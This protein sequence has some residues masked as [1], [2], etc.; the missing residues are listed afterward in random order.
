MS[1]ATSS[2]ADVSSSFTTAGTA[3]SSST[4]NSNDDPFLN[5]GKPIQ[6]LNDDQ[7]NDDYS[8][9]LSTANEIQIN[10]VTGKGI[11]LRSIILKIKKET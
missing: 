8:N 3:S 5:G 6:S 11:F 10:P 4:K 7:P 9:L 1:N 2:P